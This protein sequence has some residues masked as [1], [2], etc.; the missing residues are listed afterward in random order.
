MKNFFKNIIN[1]WL[2]QPFARFL[3]TGLSPNKLSLSFSLGICLGITPLPGTTTLS[4]T[5][6]AI[7]LRLNFGAI[8]LINY[9]V[10]P[11]Q[12]LLIIPFFKGG[13]LIT[14]SDVISGTL[15]TFID[16]FRLDWWGT[17][18]KLGLTAIAALAIWALVCIPL[19]LLLYQISL[20]VF[21]RIIEKENKSTAEVD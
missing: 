2:I 7:L 21:R 20:P 6:A 18:S 5:I 9:M 13:A 4:C 10:F 3:K 17:F 12:L 15:S 1:S 11:I 19:G 8:Q 14:G 16:R